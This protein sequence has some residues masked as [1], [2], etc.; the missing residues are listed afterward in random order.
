MSCLTRRGLFALLPAASLPVAFRPAQAATEAAMPC[1]GPVTPLGQRLAAFLDGTNVEQAWERG[2]HVDWLTGQRDRVLPGGPEAATHCSAYAASVAERLG[3]YL[4]RP[5]EHPQN[6]LANAQMGWLRGRGADRGDGSGWRALPDYVEAQRLAN[7]GEL[8][9]AVYQRPDPRKPGHIAVV[10]PSLKDRA[11]LD[12]D[13]PQVAMAGMVNYGSTTTAHGFRFH[14][15][16]W[17]PGGQGAMAFFA[18]RI[19]WDGLPGA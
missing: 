13:G 9:L 10:R 4:L 2:W 14:R 15:G 3:I 11:A 6:L 17:L 7:A 1:C 12:R 8:V 19:G 5:P 16:A 18:H